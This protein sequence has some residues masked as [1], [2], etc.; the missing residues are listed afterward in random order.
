VDERAVER[1]REHA[2][3]EPNLGLPADRRDLER[4]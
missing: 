3:V 4:H 2:L 1:L